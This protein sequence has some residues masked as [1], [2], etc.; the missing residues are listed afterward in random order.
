MVTELDS[1]FGQNLKEV[2]VWI[3]AKT[4]VVM[5]ECGLVLLNQLTPPLVELQNA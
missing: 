5:Q 1:D 3:F 2:R 4:F